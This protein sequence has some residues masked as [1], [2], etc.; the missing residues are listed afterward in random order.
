MKRAFTLIELLIVVAIIAILAAIAVPNFLQ[1]QLRAKIAAG[2]ADM[3]NI[4]TAIEAFRVDYSIDLLDA[5]DDDDASEIAKYIQLNL[6]HTIPGG[7]NAGRAGDYVYNIL[8][9]PISYMA[10]VPRDRFFPRMDNQQ[11]I[12]QTV[13]VYADQDGHRGPGRVDHNIAALFEV[14]AQSLGLMPLRQNEWVLLGAGPDAKIDVIQLAERRGVP[15]DPSNGLV[16]E[17]D[18]TVRSTGMTSS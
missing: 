8:T 4:G 13:Y 12:R 18:L 14:R 15:Y 1:A 7:T 17:G 11:N 3:R 10:A 5:W 9:T 2:V 16:S 6:G